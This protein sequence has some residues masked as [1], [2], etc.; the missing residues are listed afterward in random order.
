[1]HTN[2]LATMNTDR[3]QQLLQFVQEEPGEPFNVYALA[4]EYMRADPGQ[5]LHYLEKLLTEHPGYLATYYHAAAL[6]VEQGEIQKADMLYDMGLQLARQ[7]GNEKTFQ[8]LKRAQQAMR[9]EEDL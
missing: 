7:Q 9:D 6:Y 3:I 1:M 2:F 4:M 5:A 8:E